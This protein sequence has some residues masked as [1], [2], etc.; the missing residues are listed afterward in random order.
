[1]AGSETIRV[2]VR[3]LRRDHE[4][5][6]RLDE[7]L[8]LNSTAIASSRDCDQKTTAYPNR[9]LMPS[10]EAVIVARFEEP[11][12]SMLRRGPEHKIQ[13]DF[14]A[15]RVRCHAVRTGTYPLRTNPD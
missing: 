7:P 15:K 12:K 6:H 3:S 2:H 1:M 14:T 8:Y 13:H 5:L 9:A 11:A 10:R 4:S